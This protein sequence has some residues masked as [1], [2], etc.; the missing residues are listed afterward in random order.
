MSWRRRLKK[1]GKDIRACGNGALAVITPIKNEGREDEKEEDS[2][3]VIREQT[4]IN[5]D[6][7]LL[8][9]HRQKQRNATIS[10]KF[11]ATAEGCRRGKACMFLHARNDQCT[12]FTFPST[13]PHQHNDCKDN[14]NA[15]DIQH[16]D[17]LSL[18]MSRMFVPSS[19]KFGRRKG[20]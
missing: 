10:C 13:K 1:K 4:L 19:I 8:R 2:N 6:K 3:I 15:M 17:D 7:K 11:F 9:K 14:N 16:V 12:D 18:Q 20:R 5:K